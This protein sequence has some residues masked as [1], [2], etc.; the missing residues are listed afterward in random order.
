MDHGHIDIASPDVVTQLILD[1][2]VYLS[3]TTDIDLRFL[4]QKSPEPV[5][6]DSR[7]TESKSRNQCEST[8]RCKV[9]GGALHNN[10]NMLA[11][12]YHFSNGTNSGTIISLNTNKYESMSVYA[13]VI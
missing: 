8:V 2:S 1:H 9:T 7:K 4:F 3:N 11:S 13:P 5:S 12:W 6:A 10:N